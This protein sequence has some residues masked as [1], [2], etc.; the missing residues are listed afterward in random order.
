M[1]ELGTGS[2]PTKSSENHEGLEILT[3]ESSKG[4][5]QLPFKGIWV[6]TCTKDWV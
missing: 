5:M 2:T 4:P 1:A 6:S 3:I